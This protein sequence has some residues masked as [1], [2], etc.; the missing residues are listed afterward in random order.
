MT[1]KIEVSDCT[2][3]G[4][5]QMREPEQRIMRIKMAVEEP[6]TSRGRK[7]RL[8]RVTFDVFAQLWRQHTM[9]VL[10]NF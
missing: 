6:P 1:V 5:E 10:L 2:A 9:N 4:S 8:R 7:V 3:E